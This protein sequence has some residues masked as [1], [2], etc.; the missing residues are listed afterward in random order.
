[1]GTA[2]PSLEL[3]QLEPVDPR[4]VWK[5]EAH[6]FTPWLLANGDRLSATSAST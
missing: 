5:N 1:M 2:V 3:G 4:V 6:D